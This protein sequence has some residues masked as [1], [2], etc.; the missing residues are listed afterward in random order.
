MDN[1]ILQKASVA[2]I[3]AIWVINAFRIREKKESSDPA[4]AAANARERHEWRH[5]RRAYRALQI[6]ATVYFFVSLIGF[7]AV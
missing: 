2:L 3:L 4:I 5:I 1:A 6:I 7:L